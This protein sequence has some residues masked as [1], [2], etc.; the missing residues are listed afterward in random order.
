MNLGIIQHQEGLFEG[1]VARMRIASK[2]VR[3]EQTSDLWYNHRMY[4]RFWQHYQ[5]AMGWLQKHR[6]A[7]RK[8]IRSFEHLTQYNTEFATSHLAD[9][10]Y[11]SSYYSLRHHHQDHPNQSRWQQY[12]YSSDNEEDILK[13][14]TDLNSDTESDTENELECDV[15][16]VEITEELRQY[17]EQT[18]RHREELKRQQQF[19]AEQQ[20]AYVLADRDF[21]NPSGRT[22]QP[23]TERP[24]ERR[25]VE[26]KKLYGEGAAKIQ[27]META[28][29]LSFDRQCDKK[30]PKYWPVIPLRF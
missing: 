18:E 26:M 19:D 30:Q 10:H 24:G 22:I 14:E 5:Q 4:S 23:P 11:G 6:R 15:T 9:L 13:D 17:F 1:C 25:M 29:Q 12:P 28:M 16:N 3:M 8:A 2:G 20:T 21:H 27:G 7:Y